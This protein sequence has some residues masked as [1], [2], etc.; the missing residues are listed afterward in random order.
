MT[1]PQQD[2]QKWCCNWT[3]KV[4]YS[5]HSASRK[6]CWSFFLSVSFRS[7]REPAQSHYA[8]QYFE[9]KQDEIQTW[10]FKKFE[11]WSEQNLSWQDSRSEIHILA[12][13]TSFFWRETHFL[14]HVAILLCLYQCPILYHYLLPCSEGIHLFKRQMDGKV[15]RRSSQELL[16]RC[17]DCITSCS[18]CTAALHVLIFSSCDWWTD[19]SL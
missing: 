15:L 13:F 5:K 18:I 19:V 7:R 14:H 11:K 1:W 9:L 3:I 12:F 4:F 17:S 16:Y 10:A 2:H 6:D 8:K